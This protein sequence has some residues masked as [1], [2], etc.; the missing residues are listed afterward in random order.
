MGLEDTITDLMLRQDIANAQIIQT[1]S[2]SDL[3]NLLTGAR[4]NINAEVLNKHKDSYEKTSNDLKRAMDIQKNIYYYDQRTHD[5]NDLQKSIHKNVMM[6][7]GNANIQN[8]TNK[9][10]FE[11]NEWTSGNRRDTLFVFQT[12][13]IGLMLNTIF[14]ACYRYNIVGGAFY[15][16]I[17]FL[18]LLIIILI[19]V[20]RANYTDMLR[21]KRYWNRRQ[22]T[23]LPNTAA[24]NCPALDNA[25]NGIDK[26]V[27]AGLATLG[28]IG[29]DF[30]L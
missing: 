12:I 24:P 7:A 3:N 9:R 29:S 19:I 5:L 26:N 8:S 10:Q 15:S 23:K 20:Y 11:I 25:I 2:D 18:I 14:L 21:D 30:G 6:S 17:T 28:N 13:F 1:L 4:S 16:F 27:A 22:F